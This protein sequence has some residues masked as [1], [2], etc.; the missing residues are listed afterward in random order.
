MSKLEL[1]VRNELREVRDW[2]LC[3]VLVAIVA[4]LIMAVAMVSV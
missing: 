3:G 1:I 2:C 4:H